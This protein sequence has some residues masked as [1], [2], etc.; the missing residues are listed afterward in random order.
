M[1]ISFISKIT[2]PYTAKKSLVNQILID[3]ILCFSTENA[4]MVKYSNE[5]DIKDGKKQSNMYNKRC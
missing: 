3:I 5:G 2:L 4:T 1:L